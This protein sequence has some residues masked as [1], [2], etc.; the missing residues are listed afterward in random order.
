MA[1]IRV[2]EQSYD[3]T[4][5]ADEAK[6]KVQR[7]LEGLVVSFDLVDGGTLLMGAAAGAVT[8]HESPAA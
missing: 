4:G 8:V 3:V 7:A 2:G 5:D 1:S 6:A